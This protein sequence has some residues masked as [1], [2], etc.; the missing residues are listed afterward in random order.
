MSHKPGKRR[1]LRR[2]LQCAA[3]SVAPALFTP[4]ASACPVCH[5]ETGK[6]VRAGLFNE[7]FTSNLV[8]SIIPFPIFLG[9]VA[10]IH[11]FPAR[12]GAVRAVDLD[13]ITD[14]D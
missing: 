8:A 1:L 12:G 13:P 10:A 6:E 11:G 7:D 4:A 3:F 2:A 5:S 14:T 9:I